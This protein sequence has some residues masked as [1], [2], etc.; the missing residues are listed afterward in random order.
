MRH[1][2]RGKFAAFAVSAVLTVTLAGLTALPAAADPVYPPDSPSSPSSPSSVDAP[3]LAD[4]ADPAGLAGV[5][6]APVVD[7]L[8]APDAVGLAA[9]LESATVDDDGLYRVVAT[10]PEGVTASEVAQTLPVGVGPAALA[11]DG[12][13]V[14]SGAGGSVVV[15][16]TADPEAVI[17]EMA[18]SGLYR[19]V[20]LNM[21]LEPAA[22][23]IPK[24]PNDP[25]F[26]WQLKNGQGAPGAQAWTAAKPVGARFQS[27][28]NRVEGAGSN[29]P[30]A[31]VDT[32]FP[33]N[34]HPDLGRITLKYDTADGDSNARLPSDSYATAAYH[35]A[36][37]SGVIGATSGNGTGMTGAA[38]TNPVY[39]YK[40]LPNAAA[41]RGSYLMPNDAVAAGIRRAANDGAKVVNLSL[42]AVC[43]PSK[44]WTLD[45]IYH[46]IQDVT[47]RGVTV[48]AA[49]MN[50]GGS[51]LACPA[52][53]PNVISVGATDEAGKRAEF[54]QYNNY[55]DIA[56]PGVD[57][58][59]C[60]SV[61]WGCQSGHVGTS[62]ASPL[63]AAA[64]GL[65]KRTNPALTRL[66]VELILEH[67]SQDAGT[68]GHDTSFGHGILDADAAL[69]IA[70][71]PG[72]AK[73]RRLVYKPHAKQVVLSPDLTGDGRGDLL[74][75]DSMSATLNGKVGA[76]TAKLMTYPGTAK[77]GLGQPVYAGFGWGA[78]TIY[79]PGDWNGDRKA[80]LLAR[81]AKG[82]LYLYPG[83][84]QGTFGARS[85]VGNGWTGYTAIP[86]GDLTSDGKN[87]LVAIQNSTG[88]LF[89][90]RGNGKGG[91][92]GSYPQIGNGWTGWQLHAAGDLNSD[93]R[94]DILGIDYLG[95]L[96]RYNGRGSGYFLAKVKVGNGWS[97]FNLS[98]GASL[99]GDRYADIVGLSP[100][101]K[102]YYY[103][104][105]GGSFA[106]KIQIGQ[107]F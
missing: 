41:A 78:L 46:A 72:S 43:T 57:F 2:P 76:V 29:A 90:Y 31:V 6:E 25:G 79:A 30:I 55:V 50:E 21:L 83:T 75:V 107:G 77:G 9:A 1:L 20:G 44:Y 38:P 60:P 15:V 91:F 13:E 103:K 11:G 36:S 10:G 85:K 65:L 53:Y 8:A 81:D 18:D 4:G 100:D 26:T 64:A 3:D 98:A 34:A 99:D 54:S 71:S 102:L 95:N 88:K 17:E 61:Y 48:V 66:Q 59:V 37:V 52:S 104:G 70:K 22:N 40:T 92:S 27:A 51:A 62:Y 7:G 49:A 82:D 68:F 56:A 87:D 63:V 101:W 19:G 106:K 73:D 28:W 23:D 45:P 67:T 35:G 47:Q 58:Y 97:G 39:F 24:S 74:V 42:G 96:Y 16:E 86:A 93:G 12:I 89:L 94:N 14:T 5:G 84:G 105:T 69:A 80:D 33:A 32:A